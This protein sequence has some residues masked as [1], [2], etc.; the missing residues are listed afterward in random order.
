MTKKREPVAEGPPYQPTLFDA[1]E[2]P[3][4][5]PGQMSFPEWLTHPDTVY[6]SSFRPDWEEGPMAHVG[7]AVSASDRLV[8]SAVNIS[9]READDP[10]GGR[11]WARRMNQP[12][13]HISSSDSELNAAEWELESQ[14][15]GNPPRTLNP[16]DVS[17]KT[18]ERIM[19]MAKH[20]SE[21]RPVGYRNAFEDIGSISALAPKGTLNA[22][23]QDVAEAQAQGLP[24]HPHDAALAEQQFD[25]A[26]AITPNSMARNVKSYNKRYHPYAEI[27]QQTL[28]PASTHQEDAEGNKVPGSERL[29][30][31][32][33]EDED[34]GDWGKDSPGKAAIARAKEHAE[35]TGG[36][37]AFGVR[38]WRGYTPQDV[39]NEKAQAVSS[40]EGQTHMERAHHEAMD[41]KRRQG[42][43]LRSFDVGKNGRGGLVG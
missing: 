3:A 30:G 7:T 25:P 37:Q 23:H 24:V 43:R 12:L 14:Q 10:R 26:I 28:F 32:H 21:G 4:K 27:E 1:P 8:Q 36:V 41:T 16:N 13:A 34:V 39:A 42:E 31:V 9:P 2:A 18:D 38:P 35:A 11:T 6:H 20:L 22:W 5:H 29:F 15:R 33:P 17:F 40:L 19:G